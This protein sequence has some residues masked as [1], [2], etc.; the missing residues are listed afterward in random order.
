[1]TTTK[2]I[3]IRD[4]HTKLQKATTTNTLPASRPVNPNQ[5]AEAVLNEAR[6]PKGPKNTKQKRSLLQNLSNPTDRSEKRT[7]TSQKNPVTRLIINSP[8]EAEAGLPVAV[9]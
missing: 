3:L 1:M 8:T 4:N 6:D 9:N 2:S 7:K 5:R